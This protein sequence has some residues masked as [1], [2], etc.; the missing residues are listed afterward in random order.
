[1]L[2][3]TLLI[4]IEKFSSFVYRKICLVVRDFKE[5]SIV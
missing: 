1:M 5:C 3:K 4:K 2:I